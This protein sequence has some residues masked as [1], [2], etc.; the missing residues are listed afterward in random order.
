MKRSL[1][2]P[3]KKDEL[4]ILNQFTE[5]FSVTELAE[6]V[7]RVGKQLGLDVEIRLVVNPRLEAEDHY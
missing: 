6:R 2:H 7:R 4:R 5:T 1:E 3:A